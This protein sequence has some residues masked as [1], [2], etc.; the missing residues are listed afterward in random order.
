MNIENTL[1]K[2]IVTRFMHK[3]DNYLLGDDESLFE[4]GIIDSMGVLELVSFIE[5]HFNLKVQN[6]ELIPE[7]FKA[8][9]SIKNFIERK[10]V[11]SP[12]A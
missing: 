4:K 12:N 7:N 9:N 6:E 1:K 8:V 11:S 3:K 10:K 5:E 2:Y